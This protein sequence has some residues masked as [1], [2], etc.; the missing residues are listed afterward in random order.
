MMQKN[1]IIRSVNTIEIN[2]FEHS[3]VHGAL[4][5]AAMVSPLWI[6][7]DQR[8]TFVSRCIVNLPQGDPN[9]GG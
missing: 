6:V 8:N 4:P 7:R 1:C 3:D 5:R 2:E 9:G